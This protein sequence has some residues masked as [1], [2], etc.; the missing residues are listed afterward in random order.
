M[1]AIIQIVLASVVVALLAFVSG[2][3]NATA[4]QYGP[5]AGGESVPPETQVQ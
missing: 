3:D 4:Q 5:G 2:S 1:R